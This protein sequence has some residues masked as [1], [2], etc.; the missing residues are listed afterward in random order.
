MTVSSASPDP[1]IE[2]VG[3]TKTYNLGNEKV[4]ALR[5]VSFSV[6]RGE[7]VAIMGA[8]GSGKSTMA[9]LIGALDTPTS[10]VL[11]IHGQA[12]ASMTGDDLAHL[13]NLS[14]GFVFQQ[15]NV[16]ARMSA[17]ENVMLPL[18]Y[19]SRPGVDAFECARA[20]LQQ[21]GLGD[22][23]SHRP[24]QLSGG[25][26][27][28][29]A[30]A[31]ALVNDPKI[32]IADE[33]TGALDTHNS[34]EIMSLLSSLNEEGLT[35]VVITHEPDIAAYADRLLRFCDGEIVEDVCQRRS[36]ARAKEPMA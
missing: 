27:Q 2:C 32:V 13:R 33:P 16:M 22:R 23:L 36:G 3:L 1:A 5:G 19:S 34:H 7:F 15:F 35:L 11:K 10:G 14:I 20:R 25:Q 24:N 8:S 26:Q 31:R 30:I 21:V 17:L 12:V 6:A 29:V 9:N 18:A 28:R 4:H